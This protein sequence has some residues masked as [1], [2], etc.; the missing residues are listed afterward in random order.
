MIEEKRG[1]FRSSRTVEEVED[2]LDADLARL[3]PEEREALKVLLAELKEGRKDGLY[4]TL[5]EGEFKTKP[6]PVEQFI[7]DPYY[8]GNTCDVLYQCYIEDLKELFSG[9]YNEAIFSGAIGIG[10][11]FV[12]TVGLCRILYELSCMKD[13]HRS[14]GL[15]KD[16]NITIA[17]FSVNE[18][19]ATKV[20]FENIKTKILASPYFSKHFPVQATKKE[21]R[22]PHSIWVAPRATT[23]TSALGLNVIAAFL[24]EGN[25]LP[26][27][28]KHADAGIV[29]HADVIYSSLKRRMK[30]R[31]E[32]QGKLPG[33]LFIASS[34]TSD[35]DFVSR[36]L[37]ESKNDPAVFV[38][39]YSL[40]DIKPEAY[41][42]ERFP[43]LVGNETIPSKI[44]TPEDAAELKAKLPEGVLIID[45]PEDFRHDFERDL[46][47]SI[48]DLAGCSVVT[49][50]PFIQKREKLVEATQADAKLYGANRHPF[51][52]LT[53]DSS[54]GGTFKWEQMVR[55][56]RMRTYGTEM[57]DRPVPI[58]NPKAVRHIHI[59]IGLR[60]DSLGLAMGHIAG[61]KDV[62]RRGESGQYLESAPVYTIDLVLK[63][64]PPP[65][66]EIVLGDIRRLVYELSTHGYVITAVTTDQFQSSDLIQQLNQRGFNASLLSVDTSLQPYES[67]KT[68][69]YEDRIHVYDYPPLMQEL[70]QLQKDMA[71]RKVDH[72]RRGSKDVADAVAGVCHSLS[73]S[74]LHQPLP[75]LRGTAV[76]S[77]AWLPEQRQA[78]LAG[79]LGASNNKALDS[80]GMLPAFL[81][82]AGGDDWK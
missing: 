69:F 59:D 71:R 72:P 44:L 38:R 40:W 58:I 53:Y 46:E 20:V 39:D 5:G 33:I 42:A 22:F 64:V 27:R 17:A 24:D 34:K 15:A 78:M 6:V 81:L 82:G 57:E 7:K 1:R 19:L 36:R 67:L 80:Y 45:V 79:N 74:H 28:G 55:T 16:S 77:D 73:Q 11:S 12:S 65:G 21:L 9:G 49:V 32:R 63:V 26:K 29:D 25:F 50:S 4:K 3:S 61:Y 60:N 43:V 56:V 31:F 62:V 14:F 35:D 47:G 37:R 66:D 23:D 18:E 70:R 41:S 75:M 13:P 52:T 30:S 8:L 54:V 10:K 51:T 48:R 68:A 2:Q 76:S